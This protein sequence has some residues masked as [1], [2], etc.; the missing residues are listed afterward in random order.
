M[1]PLIPLV[2][3]KGQSDRPALRSGSNVIFTWLDRR[4]NRSLIRLA[5]LGVVGVSSVVPL[6]AFAQTAASDYTN[7]TRYDLG[8]RPVGTISPDPDGAN[9][10]KF[11][12]TRTTY[13]DRGLVVKVENGELVA[14]QSEAIAPKIGQVLQFYRPKK[15]SM[16]ATVAEF[17][18]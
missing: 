11:A 7:A 12:A 17:G 8:G 15:Q 6:A 5:A 1:R 13:N 3:R 18:Y 16:T 14:W 2:S 10:L 9:A 4:L